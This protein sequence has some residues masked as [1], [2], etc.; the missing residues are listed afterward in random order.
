MHRL[1]SHSNACLKYQQYALFSTSLKEVTNSKSTALKEMFTLKKGNTHNIYRHS[2]QI[3][4]IL[5]T[6]D[7]RC[8]N[9]E[10][11]NPVLQH[12]QLTPAI[13]SKF[14]PSIYK[15]K[16]VLGRFYGVGSFI[17][18]YRTL[19]IDQLLK[20]FIFNSDIKQYHIIE[21]G[22]GFDFRLERILGFMHQ[23]GQEI[24]N[25]YDIYL[26]EMDL[27]NVLD[28]RECIMTEFSGKGNFCEDHS[29]INIQRISMRKSI[30]DRKWIQKLKENIVQN[31]RLGADLSNV[32]IISEAVFCSIKPDEMENVIMR[33]SKEFQGATLVFDFKA[34]KKFLNENDNKIFKVENQ[35]SLLNEA[36]VRKNVPMFPRLFCSIV[37]REAFYVTKLRFL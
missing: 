30:F 14:V 19:Y 20:N 5:T 27:P 31:N 6:M 4:S 1:C 16:E 32:M 35:C 7:N 22:I 34:E 36:Q 9:I 18:A 23:N 33:L 11:E 29:K 28:V 25:A 10:S 26:Y 24:D 21:L 2:D 12:D 15:H 13:L 3:L 17:E 8:R 37:S